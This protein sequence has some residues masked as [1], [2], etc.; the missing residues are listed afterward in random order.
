MRRFVLAFC[1]VLTASESGCLV[2]AQDDAKANTTAK[3]Q[4]SQRAP[5]PPTH[6][7]R[8]DFVVQELGTDGKPT[9][10]R[11]YSTS[12]STRMRDGT[13]VI[14][15]GSK[16]PI[17]TGAYTKTGEA[18]KNMNQ[19]Q[20]LDIGVNITANDTH[21]VGDQLAVNLSAEITSLASP[22]G[23]ST[24]SDPVIRQNKWQSAVLIPIGKRTVVFAS[25]DLDSKGGMQVL[26]TA[27]RLE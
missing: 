15:T 12:V 1:I 27:T 19:I 18:D 25:D 26:L 2:H 9:N 21:E 3:P 7:Y 13:S 10:S 22:A 8:L 4:E 20:Y 23:L 17:V 11:S 16:I 24:A 14:R 5:E 6:Y